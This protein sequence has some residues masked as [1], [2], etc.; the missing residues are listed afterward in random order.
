MPAGLEASVRSRL[1]AEAQPAQH[2]PDASPPPPLSPPASP[3][4]VNPSRFW[5]AAAAAAACFVAGVSLTGLLM[6]DGHDGQVTVARGEDLVDQAID[7]HVRSLMADHLVDVKSSDQHT[8][9]P[10]FAGR[11]DFSPVVRDFAKQGYALIGGRLDYLAHATVA[12]L[13]YRHRAH[14]I[15][16]FTWPAGESDPIEPVAEDRRGYHVVQWRDGGMIWCVVSDGGASTLAELRRLI[17]SHEPAPTQP[18]R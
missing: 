14:T 16:V 18:V 12:A 10:W 4:G 5:R 7:S 3:W 17:Q 11:V 2:I 6:H 13:V 8:V 15:N 9:Q 1:R